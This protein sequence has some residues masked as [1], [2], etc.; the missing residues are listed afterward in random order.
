MAVKQAT[1]K[2]RIAKPQEERRSDLLNASAIVFAR[3]GVAEAKVE[4][5]TELAGVSKGTFYLYFTSKDEAASAL[6]QRYIDE[7]IR[8]GESVLADGR[9]SSSERIAAVFEALSRYVLSK[10]E[11]HRTVYRAA[12]AQAEKI[13]ANQRLIELIVKTVQR[14]IAKGE[15]SCDE[16]E[17]SV[18]FLY[19]GI[20]G[21]LHD[22]I[23]SREPLR[24]NTLIKT[25]TRMAQMVFPPL[26]KRSA[27]PRLSEAI[28]PLRTRRA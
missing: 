26:D 18:R 12:D 7:F 27:G 3:S 13:A 4:D 16:P 11:M 17:L 2:L 9:L 24:A 25:G 8:I 5:I 10:A 23:S 21:G 19:H 1:K 15:L 14:G 22:A 28:K 20:C 6:W